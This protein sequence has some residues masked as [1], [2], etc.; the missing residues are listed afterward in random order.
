MVIAYFAF[1]ALVAFDPA[2]AGKLIAG[3][4]VSLGVVLGALLVVLAPVLIAIYV[5][6][7]NRHYDP[8]IEA[9]RAR[10]GGKS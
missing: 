3:D 8:A 9:A 4:R 1:V 2:D 6:W 5:R 7:A 10:R